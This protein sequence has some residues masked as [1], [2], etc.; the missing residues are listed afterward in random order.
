MPP[1]PLLL[2]LRFATGCWTTAFFVVVAT[3]PACSLHSPCLPAQLGKT[4]TRQA[5][6][7]KL[8]N[9]STAQ[10]GMDECTFAMVRHAPSVP[11]GWP[12]DPCPRPPRIP[13]AQTPGPA[14]ARARPVE[15]HSSRSR[16]SL[17]GRSACTQPP[18]VPSP[19]D[20]TRS[21]A[22]GTAIHPASQHKSSPFSM[23]QGSHP[24]RHSGGGWACCLGRRGSSACMPL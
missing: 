16:R 20:S 7:C 11:G 13:S 1:H 14:R 3:S 5:S 9:P 17:H 12:A 23:D 2:I 4:V 24:V 18:P 8:D 10:G 19:Q 22:A 21:Q 15:L 6:S